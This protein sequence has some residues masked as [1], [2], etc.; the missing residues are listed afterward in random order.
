MLYHLWEH[1]PYAIAHWLSRLGGEMRLFIVVAAGL[2]AACFGRSSLAADYLVPAG[3]TES[4]PITLSSDG[5]ELTVETGGT[6]TVAIGDAAVAATGDDFVITNAGVIEYF[7]FVTGA[8]WV[9]S[10]NGLIRNETTGTISSTLSGIYVEDSTLSLLNDGSITADDVGVFLSGTDATIINT[11]TI[12][13]LTD[14]IFAI[15]SNLTIVNSG[16]IFGSPGLNILL[17][18]VDFYN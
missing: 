4:S 9:N 7:D 11:G 5:D 17:S 8:I 10:S 3:T 1:D 6:L 16:S 18:T 15:S 2:M 13:A 12:N 14:G